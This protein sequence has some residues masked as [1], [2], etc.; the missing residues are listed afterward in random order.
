MGDETVDRARAASNNEI[1]ENC[2]Y[3]CYHIN[4][5]RFSFKDAVVTTTHCIK[6]VGVILCLL[7]N[8]IQH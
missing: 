3:R 4:C 8:V 1:V 2:V 7:Q 6:I 5:H